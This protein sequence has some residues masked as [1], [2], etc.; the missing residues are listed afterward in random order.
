MGLQSFL[1]KISWSKP[2]F[3]LP[4]G[5]VLCGPLQASGG[6]TVNGLLK[7]DINVEGKLVVGR[8]AEIKGDVYAIAAE[9]FG[10]VQGNVFC[11][12]VAFVGN[13]ALIKGNITA[14]VYEIKEGALIEGLIIKKTDAFSVGNVELAVDETVPQRDE[15]INTPQLPTAEPVQEK[16][17]DLDRD[18]AQW[19]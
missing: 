7:G 16:S 9:I 17:T 3:Y 13:T 4:K 11:T 14:A 1:R 6:G 8:S 15:L 2:A 12:D 5:T 10:N 19:F 18:A